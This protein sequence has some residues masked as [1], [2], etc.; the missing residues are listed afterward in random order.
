MSHT[1]HTFNN[2]HNTHVCTNVPQLPTQHAHTM[3]THTEPLSYF[4]TVTQGYRQVH[5]HF[6]YTDTHYNP[7]V[8]LG[9][10]CTQ[11]HTTWHTLTADTNLLHTAHI[12]NT[13][14]DPWKPHTGSNASL[15]WADLP[16]PAP[17]TY[18]PWVLCPTQPLPGLRR[19]S[20]RWDV[21]CSGAGRQTH[22]PRGRTGG[23]C[24]SSP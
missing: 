5:T 17:C 15:D 19:T 2:L 12:T 3:G 24:S 22:K 23:G 18:C 13:Q 1:E 6:L 14:T 4:G 9:T 20:W 11:L 7:L 8:I 21:T 10:P 16:L